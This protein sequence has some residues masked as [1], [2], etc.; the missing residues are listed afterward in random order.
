MKSV[1]NE[2]KRKI[3]AETACINRAALAVACA[4]V[5]VFGILF[6]VNGVNADVYKQM[7]KPAC[8]LPVWLMIPFFAVA[9]CVLAF[10]CVC[11]VSFPAGISGK[12]QKIIVALYFAALA[13][14]C[15]WIPLTYKAASFFAAFLVCAVC[16]AVLCVLYAT[17]SRVGKLPAAA[18][19]I[20]SVWVVYLAYFSMASFFVN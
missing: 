14:N 1:S 20:Y 17:V 18:V 15:V 9:L 3:R 4:A 6:A 5:V 13:L 2:I 7:I 10:S 8:A 19:I 16:L 12:R 11:A